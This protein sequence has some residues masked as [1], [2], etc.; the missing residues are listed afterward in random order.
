MRLLKTAEYRGFLT[1][2][3]SGFSEKNFPWVVCCLKETF[4]LTMV[5]NEHHNAY[6]NIFRNHC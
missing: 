2:S 3:Y 5:K 1:A 4:D 6:E